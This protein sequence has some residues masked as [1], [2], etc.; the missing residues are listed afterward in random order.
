MF[1]RIA[2]EWQ[3][4]S[5]LRRVRR[6]VMLGL[7]GIGIWALTPY[8]YNRTANEAFPAG[9]GAGALSG[10]AGAVAVASGRFA[11][12]DAVHVAGGTATIYRLPGG[13]HVL[14]LVDFRTTNGPDLFIGLSGH[15]C[16]GQAASCT[17][18]VTSR[19][20][21]SRPTRATRTTSCRPASIPP[22]SVRS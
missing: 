21:R 15:P 3:E 5:P 10:A 12:A 6:V 14:R 17:T 22:P 18:R 4:M 1:A 9:A 7:L 19:C 20:W 13:G 8:L 2:Q 16:P 11:G